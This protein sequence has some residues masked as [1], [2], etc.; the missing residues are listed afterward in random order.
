MATINAGIEI[1]VFSANGKG[2]HFVESGGMEIALVSGKRR[3]DALRAHL[4]SQTF[5]SWSDAR[6][7]AQL[8]RAAHPRKVAA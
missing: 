5:A 8:W 7:S 3:R 1:R 6:T 2:W 4:A